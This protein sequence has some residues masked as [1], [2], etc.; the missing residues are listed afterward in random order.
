MTIVNAR[1]GVLEKAENPGVPLCKYSSVKINERKTQN[2][3]RKH[4][5]RKMLDNVEG[6]PTLGPVVQRFAFAAT[7][8][9]QISFKSGSRRKVEV[10]CRR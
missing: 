1:H 3:C 2:E 8:L 4:H 6:S 10:D 9:T 5:K 7:M